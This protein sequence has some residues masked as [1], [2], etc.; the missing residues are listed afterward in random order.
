VTGGTGRSAGAT[1]NGTDDGPPPTGFDP[2]TGSG[3]GVELFDGAITLPR[4][5]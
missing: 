5:D 1:G 3:S 4:R 2:A